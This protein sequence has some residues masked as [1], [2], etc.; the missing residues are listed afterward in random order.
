[1]AKKVVTSP[2][3][4]PPIAPYAAAVRAGKMVFLS[5]T[6]GTDSRGK[7][8]GAA[9]GKADMTAQAKQ[10]F[11]G[12]SE[13]LRLLG[14]DLGRIAQLK[15]FVTDWKVLGRYYRVARRFLPSQA[16]PAGS[17]VMASLAQEGLL[18]EI[19]GTAVDDEPVFL[20]G[21]GAPGPFSPRGVLVDNLLFVSACYAR[22]SGGRALAKGDAREQS[23]RALEG[24]CQTLEAAEF[25]V[26]DVVRTSMTLAD[27][28]HLPA[29]E[30]A[31]ATFFRQ[32][33]P[34]MTVT[35]GQL[36]ARGLLLGVEAVACKS[37]KTAVAPG[38]RRQR[39]SESLPLLS[40][41]LSQAVR[42]G[43]LAY[44]SGLLSLT[45]K[46]RLMGPG[47]IRKQ[48][49]RCLEQLETSL[50]LLG[51]SREDVVKTTVYITDWREYWP[52]NDVYGD[53]FRPPYPARSTVQMGLPIPGALIQID[54]IAAAGAARTAQVAVS[55]RSLWKR[56]RR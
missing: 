56:G 8:A 46:G 36:P 44:F 7:L 48:T 1:M 39:W 18:L 35:Q 49:R 4:S 10:V 16:R 52:Y 2:H 15:S 50:G 22:D 41:P 31:Y 45:P 51:L 24:L 28:R 26:G 38:G 29:F 17:T 9:R 23:K 33:Y 32:P 34:A 53:F 13:S 40:L 43:G 42:A 12:I 20:E 47:D 25:S 11:R 30:R 6:V 19:E 14:S 3:L 21:G 55:D 37:P 27:M 54:A 5:G